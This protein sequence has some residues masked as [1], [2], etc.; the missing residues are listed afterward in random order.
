[1]PKEKRAI[2]GVDN[3]HRKTWDKAEFEAKAAA[4]EEK[5]RVSDI[6]LDNG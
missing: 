5:A 3:T 1:M 4:R 6:H 2:A